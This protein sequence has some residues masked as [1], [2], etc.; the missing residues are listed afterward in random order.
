M[1]LCATSQRTRADAA[2]TIYF[3]G[4]TP[5]L[6]TPEQIGRILDACRSTFDL[7]PDA[8]ITLEANPNGVDAAWFAGVRAT[9]RQPPE[10]R[11]ANLRSQGTARARP[12]A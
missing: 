5:S 2:Q 1:R 9:G 10:H 4:G 6:L 8:E 11:R 12:A 7:D 3:G